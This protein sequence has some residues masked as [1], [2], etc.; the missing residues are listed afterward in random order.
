MKVYKVVEPV[1]SGFLSISLTNLDVSYALGE[2]AIPKIGML[3]CFENIRDLIR[4]EYISFYSERVVLECE[5]DEIVLA[6]RVVSPLYLGR[7]NNVREF[8][9]GSL[10]D[11]YQFEPAKGTYFAKWLKPIRVLT[12]QEILK[13]EYSL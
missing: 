11:E 4:S 6:G 13:N 10:P 7:E 9:E 8:W 12:S 1:L 2:K 3:F 5:T